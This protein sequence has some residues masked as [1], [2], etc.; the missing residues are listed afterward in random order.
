MMIT[1]SSSRRSCSRCRILPDDDDL[2]EEQPQQ[3]HV[4]YEAFLETVT[5]LV[6]GERTRQQVMEEVATMFQPERQDLLYEFYYLM[7]V[8]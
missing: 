7:K 6:T 4:Q 5:M 8:D 1:R 3:Q 2:Q